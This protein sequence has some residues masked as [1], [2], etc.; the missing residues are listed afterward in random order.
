MGGGI[1]VF[2]QKTLDPTFPIMHLDR[3]LHQSISAWRL[4][5]HMVTQVFVCKTCELLLEAEVKLSGTHVDEL[6]HMIL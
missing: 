5:K 2:S 6:Y 4:L 1:L 3:V